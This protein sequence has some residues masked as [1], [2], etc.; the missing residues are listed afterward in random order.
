MSIRS[1]VLS[2]LAATLLAQGCGP[3]VMFP[4]GELSGEVKPVPS[5]WSFTDD[6]ETFQLETRPDDPYSVNVWAVAAN[7][8]LYVASGRGEEGG[9]A[10]HIAADPRVRLRAGDDL[11]ELAAVMTRDDAELDAF[12]AAA[13][14]KYDFD[15]EPE[16]R[17]EAVLFRLETR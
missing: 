6:V 7:D 8:T 3:L 14:K 1:S 10:K 12:L 2:I 5:D 13:Q 17:E 9:W 15:P 4:G 16:Q 11:Y